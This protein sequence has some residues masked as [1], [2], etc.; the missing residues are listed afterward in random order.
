MNGAMKIVSEE[1]H[2]ASPR[3]AVTIYDDTNV[4]ETNSSVI[5]GGSNRRERFVG[6]GGRSTAPGVYTSV[7]EER[8][9]RPTP[10]ANR[11]VDL[12]RHV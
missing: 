7:H 10:P 8:E 2:A 9:Y 6:G 1:A 5:N 4:A 12:C 11:A 3:Y